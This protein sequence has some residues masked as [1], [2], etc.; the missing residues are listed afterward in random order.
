MVRLVAA[1]VVAVASAQ[2]VRA[3]GPVAVSVGYDTRKMTRESCGRKAVEAMG[4]KAKFPFAEVTVDGHARGWDARTT[5]MVL[6]FPLPDPERVFVM[7]VVAGGETKEADRVRDAIQSHV[8]DGPYNPET[9]VRL[10]PSDGKAPPRPYTLCWKSEDRGAVN[11]LRLYD[12]A[13]AI[14]LEKKGFQTH[15]A[16]GKVLGASPTQ[17]V[18]TFVAPTASAAT[19]RL[20][21][22][23]APPGEESG[24]KAAEDILARIAKILYD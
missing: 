16:Q 14:T 19:A 17:G 21:V 2:A 11:L 24:E 18:V 23:F 22:V 12:A 20:N 13:A 7:V 15:Q 5:V 9:P 8:F 6:S 1:L 4:A 3:D 10:T